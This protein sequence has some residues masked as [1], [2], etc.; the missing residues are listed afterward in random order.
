MLQVFLVSVTGCWTLLAL[1]LAVVAP[2]GAYGE[3]RQVQAHW[4]Q[5]AWVACL[6]LAAYESLSLFML[7][8]GCVGF[9]ALLNYPWLVV[10]SDRYWAWFLVPFSGVGSLTVLAMFGWAALGIIQ[11]RR[12]GLPPRTPPSE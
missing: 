7:M 12:Y 11:W 10:V 2:I 3:Y 1:L 9:F 5:A 8:A 6:Y 4:P